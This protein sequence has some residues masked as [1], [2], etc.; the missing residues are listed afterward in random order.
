MPIRFSKL[1]I[2]IL[3]NFRIFVFCDFPYRTYAP[4]LR[5]AWRHKA[6]GRTAD[7]A[8][9]VVQEAGAKMLLV[10]AVPPKTDRVRDMALGKFAICLVLPVPSIM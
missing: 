1:F 2:R 10:E 5:P 3:K 8:K 6:Q 4:K 9:L 7:A